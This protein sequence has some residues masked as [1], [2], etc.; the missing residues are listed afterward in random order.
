MHK[1]KDLYPGKTIIDVNNPDGTFKNRTSE[2]A[3]D[4]TP[5]ERVWPS[6]LWGFATRMMNYA[7][8]IADGSQ[9]N[10]FNSQ[11]FQALQFAIDSKNDEYLVEYKGDGTHFTVTASGGWTTLFARA[12]PYKVVTGR[13][14]SE[15]FIYGQCSVTTTTYDLQVSNINTRQ[16]QPF[17]ALISNLGNP[18]NTFIKT[19][20]AAPINL[21]LYINPS[22]TFDRVVVYGDFLLEEKPPFVPA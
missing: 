13:W 14:H 8:I 18:I 6:D 9:E 16:Y 1:L 20:N 21:R 19:R 22:Q 11:I 7:S 4:E 5:Y 15:L 10:K 17:F 12:R 2:I 3:A